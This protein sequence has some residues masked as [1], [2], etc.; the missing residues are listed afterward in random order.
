[1]DDKKKEMGELYLMGVDQE[2]Y[3]QLA[4]IAKKQGKSVVEVASDAMKK[5]I[6]DN[7]QLKE[8]KKLLMEG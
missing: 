3:A 5:H 4:E 6:A 7:K 2:S 8:H 1:M